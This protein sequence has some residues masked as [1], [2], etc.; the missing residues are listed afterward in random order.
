MQRGTGKRKFRLP[1]RLWR[2]LASV[3]TENA[4][5]GVTSA[6]LSVPQ[7]VI[8]RPRFVGTVAASRALR[9]HTG[10]PPASHR[11]AWASFHSARG[12]SGPAGRVQRHVTW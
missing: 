2:R 11:A 9:K 1:V 8:P 6:F 5:V 4:G 12:S 7:D 3:P 10:N